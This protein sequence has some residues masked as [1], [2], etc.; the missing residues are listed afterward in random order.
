MHRTDTFAFASIVCCLMPIQAVAETPVCNFYN[1]VS[2][3]RPVSADKAPDLR[4]L[5]VAEGV[6][7]V[8]FV[9]DGFDNPA[10]PADKS[11][12]RRHAYITALDQVIVTGTSGDYSCAAFTSENAGHPITFGFLPTASLVE[13]PQTL[14][15][16]DWTGQWAVSTDRTITISKDSDA[17]LDIAVKSDFADHPVAV[18]PDNPDAPDWRVRLPEAG[19][20]LSFSFDPDD[21]DPVIGEVAVDKENELLCRV[22]LWRLGEYLVVGDNGCNFSN[23]GTA[24]G[25]YR[26]VD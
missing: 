17:I 6:D 5:R 19:N 8:H 15:A 18:D 22:R 2:I 14:Q 10:C 24:G 4:V 3:S 13:F 7:K 26:K 25:V 9:K 12:C 16:I 23:T 20:P 21:D 11:A 1:D